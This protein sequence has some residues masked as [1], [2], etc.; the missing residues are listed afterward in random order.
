MNFWGAKCKF[1][2]IMVRVNYMARQLP[3]PHSLI[4][5]L[6]R[7]YKMQTFKMRGY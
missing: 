4:H 7:L 2:A 3:T 1:S 5:H 6:L